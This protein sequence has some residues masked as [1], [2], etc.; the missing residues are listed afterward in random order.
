MPMVL[1]TRKKILSGVTD[2]TAAK[3]IKDLFAVASDIATR[4]GDLDAAAA[5][6]EASTHWLRYSMLTHHAN[7]GVPLVMLRE[8][9]GH[10]NLAT[11]STYLHT[12]DHE[13]HDALIASLE[14][15]KT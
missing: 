15:T 3:A 7:T 6:R 5:L 8:T 2:E 1:S 4:A 14:T 13:R 12:A 9:A 10:E 11:T